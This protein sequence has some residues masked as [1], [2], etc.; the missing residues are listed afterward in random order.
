[1]EDGF[2]FLWD[3]LIDDLYPLTSDCGGSLLFEAI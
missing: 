1:M 3:E 2:R